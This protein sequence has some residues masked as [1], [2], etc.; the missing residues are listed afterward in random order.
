MNKSK[1]PSFVSIVILTA[2]TSIFWVIF[3]V[4][5]IFST[6]PSPKVSD[7]ILEAV[8][9][10]LDRETIDKIRNRI[11]FE[12]SQIPQTVTQTPTPAPTEEATPTATPTATAS[13]TPTATTSA[14]GT[15]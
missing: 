9:P 11:F 3:G 1:L 13:A 8:D 5:R 10:T 2:I 4:Y 7:E 6:K 12:E 15:Q 14:Q